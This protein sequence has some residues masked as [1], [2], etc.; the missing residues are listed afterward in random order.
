MAMPLI[1]F[2]V[3]AACLGVTPPEAVERTGVTGSLHELWQWHRDELLE[4]G[5]GYARMGMCVEEARRALATCTLVAGR[6]PPVEHCRTNNA[7]FSRLVPGEGQRRVCVPKALYHACTIA[8]AED[9]DVAVA[10]EPVAVQL[11][12]G[13]E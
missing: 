5:V 13:E 1:H 3:A 8:D 6:T 2:V 7:A 9:E 12:R 4:G 10:N 11:P